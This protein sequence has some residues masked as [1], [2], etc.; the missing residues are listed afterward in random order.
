MSDTFVAMAKTWNRAPLESLLAAAKANGYRKMDI[1]AELK[2]PPATLSDWIKGKHA[3]HP[4]FQ[5][6]F[7]DLQKK[8]ER[9]PRK[10]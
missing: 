9:K 6:L 4:I 8:F 2:I 3:P 10:K 5:T 7:P 1:A